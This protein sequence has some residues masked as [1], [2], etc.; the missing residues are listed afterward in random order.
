MKHHIKV[1]LKNC[2]LFAV[3]VFAGK[4]EG[5]WLLS[6]KKWIFN[7]ICDAG[8]VRKEAVIVPRTMTMPFR[9]IFSKLKEG[10]RRSKT[11]NL[12]YPSLLSYILSFWLYLKTP[13][14]ALNILATI[15]QIH[16]SNLLYM[17]KFLITQL[18]LDNPWC[19][20]IWYGSDKHYTWQ[21]SNIFVLDHVCKVRVPK[22]E[23]FWSFAT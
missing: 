9:S 19:L 4:P 15:F 20:H 10:S 6:M 21:K 17:I 13:I 12:R 7:N 8:L 16:K 11:A 14:I 1:T 5:T 22:I 18:T 2:S 3:E 23:I